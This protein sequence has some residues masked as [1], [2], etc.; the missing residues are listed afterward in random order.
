MHYIIASAVTDKGA[1]GQIDPT[2]SQNVKTF[3]SIYILFLVLFSVGCWFFCVV[4]VFTVS[5]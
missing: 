5:V 2:A 1:E 3:P 4:R